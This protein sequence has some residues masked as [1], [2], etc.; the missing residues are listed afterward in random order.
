[1]SSFVCGDQTTMA[2]AE[3]V[4]RWLKLETPDKLD[5]ICDWLRKGNEQATGAR[6]HEDNEHRKVDTGKRRAYTDLEIIGSCDCLAYQIDVSDEFDAICSTLRSAADEIR[7]D[8]ERKGKWRLPTKSEQERFGGV[9]L[10]STY[11]KFDGTSETVYDYPED[12]PWSI[13]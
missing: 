1:M 5:L 6:Y 7:R 8:G 11:R 13:D 2:A 12:I 4:A 10:P 9:Y 3:G